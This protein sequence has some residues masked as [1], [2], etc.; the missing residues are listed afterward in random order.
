[1][2]SKICISLF[3]GLIITYLSFASHAVTLTAEVQNSPPKYVQEEAG[4][5]GICPDIYALLK[6]ELK[7]DGID[8]IFN[9]KAAPFKRILANLKSKK[10]DIFCG[11]VRNEDRAKIY[12]FSNEPLYHVKYRLL[13][14][15]NQPDN[16]HI[17]SYDDLASKSVIAISGTWSSKTLKKHEKVNLFETSRPP[18]D[19]LNMLCQGRGDYFFY[20]DLALRWVNKNYQG[21]CDFVVQPHAFR[22]SAHWMIYSKGVS[23]DVRNKVNSALTA[24]HNSNKIKGIL[25]KHLGKLGD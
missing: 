13:G 19:V 10:S 17:T 18:S 5:N 6:Y 22:E 25:E 11:A 23:E 21:N 12:G 20:Q 15:A 1:M 9:S 2:V 7:D 3:F 8:F 14:H 4:I 16:A 24:L